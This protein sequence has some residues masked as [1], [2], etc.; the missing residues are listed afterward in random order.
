MFDVE[1]ATAPVTVAT[2][3]L[4]FGVVPCPGFAEMLITAPVAEAK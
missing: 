1:A 4:P 3:A 2:T